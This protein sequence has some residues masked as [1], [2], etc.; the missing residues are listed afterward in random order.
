MGVQLQGQCPDFAFCGVFV[1]SKCILFSQPAFLSRIHPSHIISPSD[2]WFFLRNAN[3]FYLGAWEEGA[4]GGHRER[5]HVGSIIFIKT[6]IPLSLSDSLPDLARVPNWEPGEDGGSLPT[7]V[8][9]LSKLG[10]Q[11]YLPL[12]CSGEHLLPDALKS[13]TQVSQVVP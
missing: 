12:Y 5:Q 1:T 2:D 4:E 3:P 9:D 10:D 6:L 13:P 8:F 11:Q 7:D